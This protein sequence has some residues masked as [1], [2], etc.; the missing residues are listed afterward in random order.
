MK[1]MEIG[2][3]IELDLRKT[4]EHYDGNN[5][6]RLNSGRAG[7]LHAL[8]IQGM[9]TIYIPYY[10]CPSVA[11]FLTAHNIDV[12][13]YFL[14]EK[15]EPVLSDIDHDAA[16][17]IVNY[18]GVISSG[19]IELWANKFK[20]VI[21]DN[22]QAFFNKPLKNHLN[23]YS[24]RKFFGVPD[25]SYVIGD[26]VET[27]KVNY[28][29]DMSSDTAGFLLKRIEKGCSAVYAE[30]MMNEERI[31][32]SDVLQMS[33]LTAELLKSVDYKY[34]VDRRVA[35]FK[36]AHALL[37]SINKLHPSEFMDEE[38]VPMVYPLVLEKEDMVKIL[39]E[40][41][42]YTG[43]WWSHVLT[44]V[45]SGSFESYLSR[46]MIPVPIDQRYDD[47]TLSEIS[48]VILNSL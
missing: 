26:K 33:K 29:V 38:C 20:N 39:T 11:A 21:I 37:G 34:V 48:R 28:P 47:S 32:S 27:T 5:V 46:Y 41:Q 12:R 6:V 42:I 25:G 13:Q 17:L 8:R 7:I 9:S 30:R 14:T 40:N 1:M 3:F 10:Q 15:F 44:E 16:V 23:V 45:P 19:K 18:F 22:S 43:R 24:P 4:G 31:N 35:N 36:V 2:S